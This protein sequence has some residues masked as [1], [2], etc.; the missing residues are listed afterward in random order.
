VWKVVNKRRKEKTKVLHVDDFETACNSTK[1]IIETPRELVR[2]AIRGFI[3][4]RGLNAVF[5]QDQ[6]QKN[7]G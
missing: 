1:L 3:V 6:K 7:R 5:L 2:L 4:S